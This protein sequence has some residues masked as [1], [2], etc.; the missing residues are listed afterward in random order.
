MIV[1]AVLFHTG[2][3]AS[4]PSTWCYFNWLY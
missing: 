1:I 2:D 4:R 3:V